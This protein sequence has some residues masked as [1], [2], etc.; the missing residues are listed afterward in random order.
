MVMKNN[1]LTKQKT[2]SEMSGIVLGF[3]V[4]LNFWLN[5]MQLEPIAASASNL[6]LIISLHSPSDSD[7]KLTTINGQKRKLRLGGWKLFGWSHTAVSARAQ[8]GTSSA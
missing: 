8:A 7:M 2:F 4:S 6:S 3:C 1:H 5:R